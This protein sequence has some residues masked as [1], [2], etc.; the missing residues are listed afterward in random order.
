MNTKLHTSWIVLRVTF[1]AVPIIAGLD[2]FT[3]ILANWADYL[4]PAVA[5]LLPF[6]PHAFM[7]IVGVIEIAA[8]LLVIARPRIGGFLVTGWLICIGLSL[9]AS[10]RYLDVA[11]RDLVMA[12]GAYTLATLTPIVKPALPNH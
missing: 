8:G 11:V 4:N 10:G 7:G 12:V 2:K 5:S 9:L 3:N 6:G 1:A